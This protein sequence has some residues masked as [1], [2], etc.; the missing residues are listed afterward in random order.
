MKLYITF[1]LV[2]VIFPSFVMAE[3]MGAESAS[4]KA[5]MAS[6]PSIPETKATDQEKP[7][8]THIGEIKIIR[9]RFEDT[10]LELGRKHNL[11]YVEIVAANP[12]VDPWLPGRGTRITL[13]SKHLIPDVPHKGIVVNLA[14]MRMYDFVTD[15]EN[16]KTYPLGIGRDGL[17]TPLGV[18]TITRKKEGP[19]WRPTA[20]MRREDP[21]LPE[22]VPPGEDNPLGTHALYLGWPQYLI[23]GTHK[24]LGV[25][26]RVSSGC[27]RMYPEDIV[28]VFE[29]IPTGT[30]VRVI[31]Q[32]IKMAWIDDMLYLEAHA[33]GE[34][35][36]SYE[37]EG[38]ITEYRVPE[39]LFQELA[40]MAG[41]AS[42]R[43]DWE[44]IRDAVKYRRGIPVA[45]LQSRPNDTEITED[46]F[47]IE[48]ES[49]PEPK[50]FES[51][52]F[53]G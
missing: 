15:P 50:F 42:D 46:V 8:F 26:R 12:G 31:K 19:S 3:T 44:T 39:T 13:P 14:E 38:K 49:E 41:D 1:L 9:S 48:V 2:A 25:G 29:T 18:T 43:L 16:P 40:D 35:A 52:G 37:F 27:I 22:V 5:A 30:K 24:P 28:R 4:I 51:H 7:V 11:G 53:N 36:D 20:R 23:H 47:K 45:I 34:L 21:T 32:P 17:D 33:E 10:L 6:K